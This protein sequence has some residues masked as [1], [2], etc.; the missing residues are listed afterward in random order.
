MP[1]AYDLDPVVVHGAPLPERDKEGL[2]A[3]SPRS[4]PK[5]THFPQRGLVMAT[6][7]MLCYQ[8]LAHLVHK[9]LFDGD[10]SEHRSFTQ[11]SMH[12]TAQS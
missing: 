9:S 6:L 7:V 11:D 8:R 1:P 4:S 2:G 10:S 12:W 3:G 5:L